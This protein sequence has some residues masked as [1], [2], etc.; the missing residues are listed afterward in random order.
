M[1]TCLKMP[2]EDKRCPGALIGNG[3][4]PPSVCWQQGPLSSTRAASALTS[5]A[6]LSFYS[7]NFVINF[8]L[9]ML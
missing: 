2:M 7:I 5:R 8:F 9:F 4:E 6:N 1:S 3:C